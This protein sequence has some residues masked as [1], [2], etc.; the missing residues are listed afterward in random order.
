MGKR[1][2]E[3]NDTKIHMTSSFSVKNRRKEKKSKRIY[4]FVIHGL[5]IP[6]VFLGI[7]LTSG[8]STEAL[9]THEAKTSYTQSVSGNK[10]VD[11][12]TYTKNLNLASK[13]LEKAIKD[14]KVTKETFTALNKQ[15][16]AIDKVLDEKESKG[17]S[18]LGDLKTAVKKADSVAKKV[19]KT[20]DKK[21]LTA[22]AEALTTLNSVQK[23]LSVPS[24]D[25]A[26]DAM[27]N[28]KEYKNIKDD[29]VK[30][31]KKK[32]AEEK[33]KAE[34]LKEAEKKKQENKS[35]EDTTATREEKKNGTTTNT[36][37][38]KT[39]GSGDDKSEKKETTKKATTS[40]GGSK[41]SSSSASKPSTPP[42]ISK[43]VSS[44]NNSDAKRQA[45]I[46]AQQQ[47]EAE[48][49]AQAE[50]EAKRKAEAEA[51]AKRKAQAEEEARR[52]AQAEA[53]AKRKAEEEAKKKAEEEAKQ[54]VQASSPSSAISQ[55]NSKRASAGLSQLSTSGALNS[56]AQ[57]KVEDMIKNNYISHDGNLNYAS[58]LRSNGMRGT[59]GEIIHS[60]STSASGAINAFMA[61][62]SHK[63]LMMQANSTQIGVGYANGVWV[64]VFN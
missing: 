51:E 11:T 8:C 45:E 25:I 13:A 52:K 23:G 30:A 31:Q 33:K 61:S 26:K 63:A 39:D 9:S 2:Q 50:A 38:N 40:S 35:K 64:M 48:R 43:S 10:K 1:E 29:V 36:S 3:R 37:K 56:Y 21:V 24:K 7:A 16:K 18:G 44:S 19:V 57:Q 4:N 17:L 42:T 47:A 62:P 46:K 6:T 5:M 54:N 12:A 60:G 20:K 22:R 41:E 34:K 55:A 59:G 58:W 53:E 27:A 15:L 32:E 14:G 28:H 49:K